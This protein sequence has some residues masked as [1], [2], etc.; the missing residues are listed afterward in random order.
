MGD[1]P[2]VSL[3]EGDEVISFRNIPISLGSATFYGYSIPVGKQEAYWLI[4]NSY[5]SPG[6]RLMSPY[7]SNLEI[8]DKNDELVSDYHN[9]EQGEN[10]T[11]SWFVGTDYYERLLAADSYFYSVVN[12]EEYTVEAQLSKEGYAFYDLSSIPSGLYYVEG[13]LIRI[14]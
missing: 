11:V 1:V 9:L 14:G 13:G 6:D 3:E 7:Y 2:I 10:Y 8:R 5:N 4:V 12:K